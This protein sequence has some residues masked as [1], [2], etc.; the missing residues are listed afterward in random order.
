VDHRENAAAAVAIMD[1]L[2][3]QG[4]DHKRKS[5]IMALVNTMVNAEFIREQ[6]RAQ[7]PEPLPK[8]EV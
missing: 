7:H 6:W 3:R 8:D 5:E 1:R 4:F 2:E